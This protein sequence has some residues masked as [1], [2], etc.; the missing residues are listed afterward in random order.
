MAVEEI[1]IIKQGGLRIY[2]NPAVLD[3]QRESGVFYS[4][5]ER[6]PF[7]RWSFGDESLRWRSERVHP[8]A[9]TV[10]AFC[11][12]SWASLPP[13]LQARLDEHYSE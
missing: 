8:S 6:G 7:Y 1:K 4:R 9:L 3:G 5:F 12:A 13:G 11:A 10:K 2:I